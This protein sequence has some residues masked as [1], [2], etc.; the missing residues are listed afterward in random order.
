MTVTT[1]ADGRSC[2]TIIVA[3]LVSRRSGQSLAELVCSL[4]LVHVEYL[5]GCRERDGAAERLG[6]PG[7]AQRGV[8]V[9]G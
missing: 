8:V 2:Q 1:N 4:F 7:Q 6:G 3:L 5:A 9:R